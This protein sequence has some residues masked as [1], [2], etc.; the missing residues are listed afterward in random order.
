MVE[1]ILLFGLAATVILGVSAIIWLHGELKAERRESLFAR[2]V[3]AHV[4]VEGKRQ[5]RR[6]TRER[7]KWELAAARFMGA[8]IG[9]TPTPSNKPMARTSR[10]VSP[11][12][13]IHR[14]QRE[15]AGTPTISTDSVPPAIK[16]KFLQE[17]SPNGK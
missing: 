3:H 4:M 9:P 2:Q 16:S 15:V 1:T 17:T 6:L 8:R 10:F 12:E 11:T 5:I 7:N 14:T 13:A